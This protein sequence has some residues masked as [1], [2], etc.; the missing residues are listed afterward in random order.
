MH[1]DINKSKYQKGLC[2]GISAS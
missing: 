1:R 2:V